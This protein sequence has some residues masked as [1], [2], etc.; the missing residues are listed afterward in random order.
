[1]DITNSTAKLIN[2]NDNS[3]TTNQMNGQENM[4]MPKKTLFEIIESK[5]NG[6]SPGSIGQ[7]R[8][9]ENNNGMSLEEGYTTANFALDRLNYALKFLN[10][11]NKY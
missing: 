8:S 4:K 10:M 5:Q 11:A 1:M 3:N 6:S 7:N 9:K 2:D